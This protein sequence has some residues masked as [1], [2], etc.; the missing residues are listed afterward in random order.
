VDLSF[1]SNFYTS[2]IIC[3]LLKLIFSES[4]TFVGFKKGKFIW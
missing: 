3:K 2:R 4:F 1:Q